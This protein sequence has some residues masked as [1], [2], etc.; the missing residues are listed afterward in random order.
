ML[1][2]SLL[3]PPGGLLLM[4]LLGAL[5]WRWHPPPGL[6]LLLTGAVLN[7]LCSIPFTASL[8]NRSLQIYPPLTEQVLSSL[9]PEAIVVLGGGLHEDASEYGNSPTV[10]HRTLGR[11]RYAARLARQ[12]GLPVLTSGGRGSRAG[13]EEPAEAD[14]MKAILEQE[15]GLS[16]VSAETMSRNTWE[17]AVNSAALLRERHIQTVLLV[18]NA[19]HLPRAVAAFQAQGL[20][21]I[22]A[23]TLFF[24]EQLEP[25]D[26]QSWLP[27]VAAIAEIHYDG[28]EWL[29]RLWYAVRYG[30]AKK[31][32]L[33]S[34]QT[35]H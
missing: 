21:V 6:T 20:N 11:V 33:T 9:R 32:P 7:Y 12:A 35:G 14:L 30:V 26:P 2:K 3:L 16:A 27:S 28:Y 18:S 34:A 23:P 19:V 29:G 22:P 10:H 15:F 4:S 24:N 8:L 1:I 5:L 31:G 13:A 25:L 17:N